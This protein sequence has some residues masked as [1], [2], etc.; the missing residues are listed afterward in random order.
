MVSALPNFAAALSTL[1]SE[2]A[3]HSNVTSAGLVSAFVLGE[4]SQCAQAVASTRYCFA[5]G[6]S[7][8]TNVER[9]ERKCIQES[10]F[11]NMWQGEGL[12]AMLAKRVLGI[13]ILVPSALAASWGVG[14]ASDVFAGCSKGPS[15]K[16]QACICCACNMWFTSL[17]R[18]V[19]A[20][21]LTNSP[22]SRVS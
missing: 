21:W 4:S 17:L 14:A 1:R 19:M 10:I 9:C 5:H 11:R 20:S 2:A 7:H 13:E 6:R 22:G 12:I 8:I 3:R 15:H 18:S 16:V